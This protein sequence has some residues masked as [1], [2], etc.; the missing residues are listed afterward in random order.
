MKIEFQHERLILMPLFRYSL[1]LLFIIVGLKSYSQTDIEFYVNAHLLQGKKIIKVSRDFYD[2]YLW[3]LDDNNGVYRINSISKE[4]EDF[5]SQL[6]NYAGYKFSHIA[7]RS[8]DTVFVGTNTSLVIELGS[9]VVR[10]IGLPQGLMYP[11]NSIGMNYLNSYGNSRETPISHTLL[12][13]TASGLYTFNMN[14]FSIVEFQEFYN[15]EIFE[16]TYRTQLHGTKAGKFL[17]TDIYHRDAQLIAAPGFYYHVHVWEG[18]DPN[19]SVDLGHNVK[20]ATYAGFIK[21]DE[22]SNTQSRNL[23]LLWGNSKGLYEAFLIDGRYNYDRYQH[24]LDGISINKIATLY[25]LSSFG[26]VTGSF[27]SGLIR[28]NILVGTQNGLYIGANINAD[29]DWGHFQSPFTHYDPIGNLPINDI[30]VNH[31]NYIRPSFC[32]NGAWVACDNGLYFLKSNYSQLLDKTKFEAAQFEGEFRGAKEKILCSNQTLKA[33]IIP[34]YVNDNSVQWFKNGVQIVGEDKITLSITEAGVYHAVIYNPCEKI[35]IETNI[36]KVEATETPVF[37]SDYPD[38][39]KLCANQTTTL[40]INGKSAYKYRWYHNDILLDETSDQLIAGEPGI[41]RPEVS[42]CPDNWVP[43]KETVVEILNLVIPVVTAS[44]TAYCVGEEAKLTLNLPPNLAY[45]IN[46]YVNGMTQNLLKNKTTITTTLA[47]SYAVKLENE[48]Q[49]NSASLEVPISFDP[50]PAINISTLVK[51]TFC[52][53]ENIELQ[54]NFSGGTIRWSTGDLT[55][56]IKISESGTYNATVTSETGCQNSASTSVTFF[57]N[58]VLKVR[59]TVLCQFNRETVRLS[60]PAGF[61]KYIWNGAE[62]TAEFTATKLGR[63][64]LTVEDNNGCRASQDI[65]IGSFCSEIK[66]PNTFTPNGDGI[67]DSWIISGVNGDPSLSVQVYNRYGALVFRSIGY[68]DPW[69]GTKDN[70]SLP[71]GTYYY[72][73][74]AKN[75]SEKFRGSLTII[76]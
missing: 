72:I 55:D 9:G 75:G 42:G 68:P 65:L 40:K 19:F 15:G 67:N 25:G 76:Y 24:F 70:V 37:T 22:H 57:P 4:I 35:Q 53:G 47:G 62:G 44:K 48:L 63:V 32:E 73:I 74:S 52:S 60:A 8:K 28:N 46:W 2:P 30:V 36:L 17:D 54:A 38:K 29:Y 20:T 39:I 12:I 41:Y 14:R 56:K 33:E 59:D 51:T 49:C 66:L 10:T 61:R 27:G 11:V 23:R 6:S 13:G 1:L 58:P 50:L 16:S 43:A 64:S 71:Q 31:A 7:G 18:E 45:T 3:A 26:D 34:T 5:S 21:L 69:N